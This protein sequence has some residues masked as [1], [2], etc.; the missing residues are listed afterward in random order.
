MNNIFEEIRERLSCRR[1][2][3]MDK[4]E[5]LRELINEIHDSNHDKPDVETVTRFLLNYMNILDEQEDL[6]PCH[7]CQE[8]VCDDCVYKQRR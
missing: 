8:F 7:N 4:W 3:T 1:I 2:I 6:G 5:D